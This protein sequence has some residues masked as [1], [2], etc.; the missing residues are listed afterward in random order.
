MDGSYV[1]DFL[2]GD[3]GVFLF[4]EVAY[5]EVLGNVYENPTLLELQVNPEQ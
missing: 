1:I 3:D 5:N 2:S 4:D